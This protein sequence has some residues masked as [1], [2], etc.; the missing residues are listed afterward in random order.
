MTN[1]GIVRS[2]GWVD[3]EGERRFQAVVEFPEGPPD[4]PF[5]VVWDMRRI[6]IVVDEEDSSTP[7]RPGEQR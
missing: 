7:Q 1:T 6:R 5:N 2:V 4:L 3:V